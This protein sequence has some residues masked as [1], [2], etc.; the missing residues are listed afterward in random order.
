MIRM[1]VRELNDHI[2]NLVEV[3]KR[4][5]KLWRIIKDDMELD[6]NWFIKVGNKKT[7]DI[8]TLDGDKIVL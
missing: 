8:I 4:L 2:N 5:S 1:E 7:G 3:V 6:D